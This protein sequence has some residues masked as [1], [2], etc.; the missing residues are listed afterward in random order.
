M[1]QCFIY[2]VNIGDIIFINEHINNRCVATQKLIIYYYYLVTEKTLKIFKLISNRNKD[3]SLLFY[4]W[5]ISV[6]LV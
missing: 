6:T 2:Y 3:N 4:S 1:Y 5:F